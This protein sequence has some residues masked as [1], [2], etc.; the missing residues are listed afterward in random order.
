MQESTIS[1]LEDED[2]S[3]SL[4]GITHQSTDMH[5]IMPFIK[6]FQSY[7]PDTILPSSSPDSGP[8]L[9]G[10]RLE[11]HLEPA[12]QQSQEEVDHVQRGRHE[13]VIG[14]AAAVV[15]LLPH[16]IS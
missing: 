11:M 4:L 2:Y 12:I 10:E 9:A 16:L 14:N 13:I 15:K 5:N 8:G 1:K 7:C 3:W 6:P